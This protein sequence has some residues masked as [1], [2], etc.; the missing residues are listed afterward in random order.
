MKTAPLLLLLSVIL[1]IPALPVWTGS[2]VT[3]QCSNGKIAAAYFFI[4]GSPLE[5]N[6]K[7][8]HILTKVQKSDE[9]FYSCSTNEDGKSPESFLRVRDSPPST[10]S[11]LLLAT[12]SSSSP[13]SSSSLPLYLLVLPVVLVLVEGVVLWRKQR[14]GRGAELWS[15][16]GDG[17]LRRSVCLCCESPSCS[18]TCIIC[19]STT[20]GR[21]GLLMCGNSNQSLQAEC[22]SLVM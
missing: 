15:C 5:H 21:C 1:L 3:L 4:Q 6:P 11:P 10:T 2:D 12:P 7:P 20:G 14:G 18:S 17:C 22:F 16:G 9:G 19:V 8:K 13:H